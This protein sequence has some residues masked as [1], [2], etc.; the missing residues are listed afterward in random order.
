MYP[1]QHPRE[2]GRVQRHRQLPALRECEIPPRCTPGRLDSD[3]RNRDQEAPL[4]PLQFLLLMSSF[5]HY[6]RQYRRRSS[7]SVDLKLVV[8]MTNIH[9]ATTSSS[10]SSLSQH[11]LIRDLP[12]LLVVTMQHIYRMWHSPIEHPMAALRLGRLWYSLI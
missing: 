3:P 9:P 7:T 11:A 2:G 6:E 5:L 10:T 1:Y 4:S 8:V 12:Q